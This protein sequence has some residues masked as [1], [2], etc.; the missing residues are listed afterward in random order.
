MCT[1]CLPLSVIQIL[2]GLLSDEF[3]LCTE[4]LS[5]KDNLPV[6]LPSVLYVV[7]NIDIG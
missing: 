3:P 7:S 6:K 4:T 1:N 2:F 5:S